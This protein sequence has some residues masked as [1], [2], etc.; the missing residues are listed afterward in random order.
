MHT[1]I[2]ISDG[3]DPFALAIA[4]LLPWALLQHRERQEVD[5]LVSF[6]NVY[7]PP[8]W[9]LSTSVD[10]FVSANSVEVDR[11][12]ILRVLGRRSCRRRGR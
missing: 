8:C 11:G 9:M 1:P 6:A 7:P 5:T 3:E 10:D 12:G 4:D 2:L